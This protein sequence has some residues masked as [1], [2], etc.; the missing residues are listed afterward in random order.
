[1]LSIL[2]VNLAVCNPVFDR[3]RTASFFDARSCCGSPFSSMGVTMQKTVAIDRRTPLE[4]NLDDGSDTL[5]TIQY[6]ADRYQLSI[7]DS[8]AVITELFNQL[9]SLGLIKLE[10]NRDAVGLHVVFAV[11]RSDAETFCGPVAFMNR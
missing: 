2:A 9:E 6:I 1:M 3:V 10:A 11:R 7:P 8:L 5:E 4:R